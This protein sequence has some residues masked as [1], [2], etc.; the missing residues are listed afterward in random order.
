MQWGGEVSERL[1]ITGLRHRIQDQESV[2]T[3][4]WPEDVHLV[5]IYCFAA[6]AELPL[7]Q[8]PRQA[9]KLLTRDEYKAGAGYRGRIE[10]TGRYAY[11]IYPCERNA[12]GVVLLRQ[13]DEDNLVRFSTGKVQVRYSIDYRFSLFGKMRPVRIMLTSE[14]LVPKEALCYVM[15]EGSF[16]L[17]KED[18][19]A[20]PFIEDIAPGRNVLPQIEIPKSNKI[21][22]FFTDGKKYGDMYEL[23]HE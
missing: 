14:A 3:W 23:I 8:R 9:M 20:Y 5:Y 2:L 11:R 12:D 1:R 22:L 19:T 4:N 10:G 18:G 17:H 6:E 21:K 7:E 13:E 16:P 15:K